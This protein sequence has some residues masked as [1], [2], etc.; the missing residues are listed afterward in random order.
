MGSVALGLES[1]CLGPLAICCGNG[2]DSKG[3]ARRITMQAGEPLARRDRI[4]RRAEAGGW[5]PHC[6]P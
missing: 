2:V 5:H 3:G 1:G 6:T 4:L